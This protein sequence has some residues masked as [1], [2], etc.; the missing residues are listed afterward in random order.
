MELERRNDGKDLEGLLV[1]P[2][3]IVVVEDGSTLL[4]VVGDGIAVC[5]WEP[6]GKV[7]GLAHF[8]EGATRDPA[9]ATP[10]YGNV[11]I[12]HLVNLLRRW[13]SGVSLEAQVYGGAIRES[14]SR[15]GEENATI[16]RK[17]LDRFGIPVASSDTGG[18][19][20]RKIVFD[21]RS[22]HVAVIKV[23]T[24]RETDWTA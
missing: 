23:H 20:G 6:T 19:K 10:R 13:T 5:L 16:A 14:T 3:E 7:A 1:R 11:A 4:T 18:T 17:I 12:P 15:K 22:G 2:G 9:C 21:T 8:L 24:L